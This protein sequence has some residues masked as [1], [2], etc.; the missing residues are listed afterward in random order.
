MSE[1]VAAQSIKVMS[2]GVPTT[3][4]FLQSAAS[5]MKLNVD[6]KPKLHNQM[7]N[8]INTQDGPPNSASKKAKNATTKLINQEMI[9]E[10]LG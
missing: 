4:R 8:K 7:P 5:N 3:G 10:V 9:I 1:I 6:G 2:E